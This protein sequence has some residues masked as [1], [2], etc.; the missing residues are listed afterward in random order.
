MKM[1]SLPLNN[2][3]ILKKNLVL[4]FHKKKTYDDAFVCREEIVEIFVT[5]YF[6][7][8]SN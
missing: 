6:I 5:F 7:K 3:N 4:T 8:I 1:K 2:Y